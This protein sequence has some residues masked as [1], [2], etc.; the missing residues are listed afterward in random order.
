MSCL[1]VI[2]ANDEIMLRWHA[3]R[4]MI[5]VAPAMTAS[6]HSCRYLLPVPLAIIGPL[7]SIGQDILIF[8]ELGSNKGPKRN[9]LH[10]RFK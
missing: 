1:A 2:R 3:F 10:P 9:Q 6:S 5:C 8:T 7:S 4:L